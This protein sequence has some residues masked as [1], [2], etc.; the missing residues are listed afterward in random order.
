MSKADIRRK[1]RALYYCKLNMAAYEC[2]LTRVSTRVIDWDSTCF[3]A[4]DEFDLCKIIVGRPDYFSLV[5]SF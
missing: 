2:V 3:P 4:I 5:G 1:N